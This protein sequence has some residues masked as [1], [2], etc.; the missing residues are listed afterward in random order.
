[1]G[2]RHWSITSRRRKNR[3]KFFNDIIIFMETHHHH[4][5]PVTTK[6]D[7]S[8]VKVADPHAH[9]GHKHAHP[10]EKNSGHDKHAGHHTGDF[11]KRFWICIV[12]T[13]PI[14]L[15]SEMIQHWFGFHLAFNGDKYV[16]FVLGIAI[17][18]YGGYPFLTG[19]VR[20]IKHN[21]IGMMTLVAL[22]ITVAMVYSVAITF[23]L[24]GMDFYWEL[25][26]LIDIMLL[27]HWLEMRSQMAASK[28]L[29]SLVALLPSV[30]HVE[31]NNVVEDVD[32][33]DLKNGDIVVI[34]PG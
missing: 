32:I 9:A 3:R 4:H 12:L 17:Y 13:I 31:R 8:A 1:M 25:A 16:L 30:V 24:E 2:K 21:A 5:T 29:E 10:G 22:A 18:L 26:T 14:L 7:N 11:L 33:K 20:E 15:L 34:R 28:A 27:G 23:G 6:K 19:M